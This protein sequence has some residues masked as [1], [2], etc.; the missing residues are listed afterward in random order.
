LRPITEA[1]GLPHTSQAIAIAGMIATCLAPLTASAA[2][3][4]A[5]REPP[6]DIVRILD[7]PPTPGVSLNPRR[8]TLL[9]VE[10]LSL[11]PIQDLAQPMLPLAGMRI[12][13]ST[14]GGYGPRQY[15]GLSI[16]RLGDDESPRAIEL[17]HDAD[18]G[19]PSWSPDGARFAFTRTTGQGI[20]LWVG[21][22]ETATARALTG[23][24]LNAVGD[25]P[26]RWMPDSRRIIV[27]FV[28]AGRHPMPEKPTAPTGPIIQET[29]GVTSPVRT[30]QDLLQNAHDE[31]LF[32]HFVR[33]QLAI[34]D[35]TDGSRTDLGLPDL[36][37][38]FDLS[39]DGRFLLVSRT[40]RPYSYLVP[41]SRFPR[42]V[43]VWD[44]S[45]G[46]VTEIARQPLRED[47]PIQGV[48]TGPRSIQWSDTEAS[49][50][51]WAEA[52]DEGDPRNEVPHRDRIM[53]LNAPFTFGAVE[54]FRTE[55]RFSGISWMQ[56][57]PHGVVLFREYDRDRRWTRTW[58]HRLDAAD[59]DPRLV[60][61]HSVN[62]RYGHPGSPLNVRTDDGRWIVRVHEGSIYLS[63]AG[64]TAEGDLPFLDRMS[65]E[66]LQTERLWR[67]EPKTLE[68]VVD[69]LSDD[70]MRV[71]TRFESPV[72]P[73]NY[74]VRDLADGDGLRTAVTD[75]AD[76]AP[77]LR[78]ISRQLVTYRRAD[79]VQLSAT[80]YL[81]PGY[82]PGTPLPLLV[83]AYPREYNDPETAGQISGSPYR[84]L[85]IG[86]SSHLFLLLEGYAIMDG[87]TM[88]VIGD[89]ETVNDTFIDQIV[90]SAAAA[91]D[92]A[93]EMDVADPERV[94]IGGHSYG[95]FMT[96]SLLA[97]SD[98]FRAGIA[99]SGAYNRTLT[100]FGFQGERRTFWEAVDTY[101][102]LSP[103]T[104]AH[105]INQPILLI[106]GQMDANAGTFPM[107]SER[108]YH[109]IKGHGGT[110]RLVL[111]PY[112]DHGY[113]ARESV[114]HVL[115]E[116][117]DWLDLH[118]KTTAS[119]DSMPAEREAASAAGDTNHEV[120]S[121]H[122]TDLE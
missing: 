102:N 122:A 27:R 63:G 4:E 81:P 82:E 49:I 110:A 69:L 3:G 47:I 57:N 67:C 22:A 61:D 114:L 8:N 103:F 59:A 74:F 15:V 50:L 116:M 104:H 12:N 90:S 26:F 5:Y 9:L 91:I 17:P 38:W 58:L 111:L 109:A 84:F 78:D 42:I 29:L 80:L 92:T 119:I 2:T 43:E 53:V 98:L 97:H 35:V 75:F 30:F 41:M 83:W 99:R 100:P 44:M 23:P 87:A 6:A 66:T 36:Y 65:L 77:E 79:G 1:P 11:P 112:E 113:R 48:A 19:W 10:R 106:H 96:A 101:I 25:A 94:A 115:A 39:P 34:I 37:T 24:V 73:P 13:P 20:E 108:M 70:G 54:W 33:T 14:S 31:A 85:R 117:I 62:D 28:P 51:I 52:L 93:V 105:R 121:G 107:Q 32:E 88:P 46:A 72:D 16:Q 7:A 40:H 55:H 45:T 118:V 68:S 60:W 89:P 120:G 18:L 21:D 64:A 95:A 56:E 76:P 71:L 86:G